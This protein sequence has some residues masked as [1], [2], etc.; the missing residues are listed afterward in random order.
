MVVKC[1]N[2]QRIDY[3]DLVLIQCLQCCDNESAIIHK[4]MASI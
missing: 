2:I 4:A 1:W 3:A